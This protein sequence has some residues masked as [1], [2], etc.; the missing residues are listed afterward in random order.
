MTL[1]SF[2]LV[3]WLEATSAAVSLHLGAFILNT[4][5]SYVCLPKVLLQIAI[6]ADTS[7][8]DKYLAIQPHFILPFYY[9]TT[10]PTWYRP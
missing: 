5:H 10:I 1:V 4:Q 2:W 9:C 3:F 7:I 6:G 8:T